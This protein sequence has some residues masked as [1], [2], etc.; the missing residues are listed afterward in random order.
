M[1]GASI[2]LVLAS[3]VFLDLYAPTEASSFYF[4]Y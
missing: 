2:S 4:S 1:A 3:L